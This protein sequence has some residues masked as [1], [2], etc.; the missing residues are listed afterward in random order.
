VAIDCIG[1]PDEAFGA[2]LTR[3]F[4]GHDVADAAKKEQMIQDCK[5]DRAMMIQ[6]CKEEELEHLRECEGYVLV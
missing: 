3:S 5:D 2:D 1:D 6:D 4:A